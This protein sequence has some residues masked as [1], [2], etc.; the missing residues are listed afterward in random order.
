MLW[1]S[2]SPQSGW[3]PSRKHS[4]TDAGT[5][6]G[7]D[8]SLI[9]CRGNINFRWPGW[10]IPAGIAACKKT[11]CE[12]VRTKT[13]CV[14]TWSVRLEQNLERVGFHGFSSLRQLHTV[15]LQWGESLSDNSHNQASGMATS[16]FPRKEASSWDLYSKKVLLN[17]LLNEFYWMSSIGWQTELGARV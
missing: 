11:N 9:Y 1:D 16:K 5:G 7:K 12:D 2:I 10:G 13:W 3:L 15:K 4:M 17:F 14:W 8:L 6:V